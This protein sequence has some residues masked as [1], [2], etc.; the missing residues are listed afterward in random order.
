MTI[1][2]PKPPKPFLTIPKV[3]GWLFIA[4]LVAQYA[5]L[6]SSGTN[7]PSCTLTVQWP[8]Y[9]K[10]LAKS[11]INAIKLNA[12]SKCTE[13]QEFTQIDTVIRM[14][15]NGVISNIRFDSVKALRNPLDPKSANFRSLWEKCTLGLAAEYHGEASGIVQLQSGV[16]IKV[17]DISGNYLPDNCRIRAK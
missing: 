15:V 13:A 9:S 5:I 1:T 8:H 14:K 3:P 16:R 2:I 12:T 11:Q 4:A 10:S 7:N 17:A 6:N